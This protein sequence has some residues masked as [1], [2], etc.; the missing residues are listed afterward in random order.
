[1]LVVVPVVRG[2]AMSVVDV[3]DVITVRHRDMPAALAVHVVVGRVFG[4]TRRLALVEMSVVGAV[5]MSVVNVV[6]V[7][8]VRY[9]DVPA[10]GPVDVRVFGVLDMCCGHQNASSIPTD[11]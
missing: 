3:I 11:R 5:Q 9:R 4:M 2:V 8:T 1:M 10:V 7:V 6:D